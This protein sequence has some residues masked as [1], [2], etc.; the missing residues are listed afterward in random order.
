MKHKSIFTVGLFLI[1]VTV[2]AFFAQGCKDDEP[3]TAESSED[4]EKIYPEGD[5]AK[6]FEVDGGTGEFIQYNE[7]ADSWYINFDNPDAV[8]RQSFGD[9]D[10]V[11]V[12]VTNMTDEYKAFTGK[13][14]ISGTVRLEYV[15]VPKYN[16]AGVSVHHYTLEIKELEQIESK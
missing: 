2:V 14:R 1:L 10:A 16:A 11:E 3:K 4:T 12:L 5:A 13:L 7:D 15:L 9:E 6:P 8:L